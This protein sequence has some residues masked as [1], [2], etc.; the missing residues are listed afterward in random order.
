MLPSRLTT[1]ALL[2]LACRSLATQC[3]IT[4]VMYNPPA[5]KPEYIEVTNLTSNRI[6][7]AKW[8]LT[9][10]VEFTFPDFNA[11]ASS[12]HF[13]KE[14]ERIVLSSA[15]EATT[16]AAYPGIP[17]NVR[18]FGP[19]TGL[20]DNNGE[21][22]TLVDF[23]N[24]LQASMSYGDSGQWPRAADG[25]GHS[26]QIINQNRKVD[27]WRN[28]RAS[29]GR[30]GSPG[31]VEAAQ[32]EE[33]VGNPEQDVRPTVT[34]KN[35]ADT[36]KY[37]RDLADPD[38]AN[39]EGT[40]MGTAFN[41][42]AW[43]SGPGLFARETA[44][45]AV[46]LI[47]TDFIT[48]Y[49]SSLLS[50]Y[51]RT[52]F[53]WT[54]AL[55][56]TS[57]TLDQYLDD[58]VIYYLNGVE[59]KGA[60]QGRVRMPAGTVTHSTQ[61]NA[62]VTDA[63]EE[64][65]A[66]SGTLDGQLVS[67]TN[68]LCAE[69]H[70]SGTSSS[71]I[72]FGARLKLI[73][74]APVGVVLNEVKPGTAGSGFVEFYNPT[75]A[76]IDLQNYYLS[77]T[78][79]NLT[80]YQIAT[81]LVVPSLG[82]ATVGFAE[83]NLAIASPVVVILTQPD[84]TTRQA[85]ISASMAADGRSL[86]RKPAGSASWF[87]FSSP[88]P[89]AP[90]FS[91]GGTGGGA[92]LFL[93]EVHFA[94]T[95]RVD[96]VEFY[97]PATSALS[98]TGF[99]VA[100]RADLTD[101]VAL[102]GSIPA[103]G[104]ASMALDFPTDGNGDITLYLTDAGD[105]VL[106]TAAVERRTGLPSVQS[107]PARSSEWY[108]STTDTRDAA[109]NPA[110]STDIVINEI[111]YDPPSD[112]TNGEYI[113]ITNRGAAPVNLGLWRFNRGVD[114]DF[115]ANTM[116]APGEFIVVA[117]DPGYV[118]AT[119]GG[120]VRVFG[121][122]QGRLSNGGDYVRLED[123][124]QN[125]ADVV[126]YKDGGN[127]PLLAGGQGSSMEL[128]H[129]GMDNS[130]P[131]SWRASN[132]ANKAPFQ[133]YTH[134]G[135]Y[136]E[137]RTG[138]HLSQANGRALTETREL[139]LHHV[140]DGHMVLKN[141]R[142]AAAATPGTNIITTGDA[143][144]HTGNGANGF[145]CMGTHRQ[146]D[147]LADGFHLISAGGGDV[148]AN[149]AEVDI[150]GITGSVAAPGTY[151]LS[152]DARWVSGM[153][154]LVAQTW[155]RSFG[156]VFRLP[157][158]NNLGTPGAA[159][160][161]AAPSAPP[162]VD[163]ISHSPAVPTSTQAVIVTARVTSAEPLVSVS[164]RER[165]DSGATSTGPYSTVA[166]N[167][168]GTGADTTAG[169]GIWSA[170]VPA[171]AVN[172]IT[173]FFVRAT[174][175]GGQ[176]NQCPR[177]AESVAAV[178]GTSLSVYGRP[179]MWIVSNTP[180]SSQPGILTER[181]IFSQYDRNAMNS[182]TG[183]SATYDWDFPRMSN[184]GLNSTMIFNESEVIYNCELR[185]GGSP[186]TRNGGNTM[187]RARWRSPS[188]NL[189]RDRTKNAIDS[190]GNGGGT[191]TNAVARFHNRISRY[192]M[193]LFGY[194]I[195]DAE[196]VQYIVNGDDPT[197]RDEMEMTDTDFFDRAYGEGGEL[198]E[199]DDAWYMYDTSNHDERIDA[200]Q[201]TGR[202]SLTDW[203]N[204][205]IGAN[206]SD[207]SPIFFHGNWP[208]RFPESTYDYASLSSF[209]KLTVN[210]GQPVPVTGTASD[211]VLTSPGHGLATA[212][213]VIAQVVG[214]GGIINGATYY[215]IRL[216]ADTFKLATT[217][218]NANNGIAVNFNTDIT[219]GYVQPPFTDTNASGIA[220]REQIER[221]ID[222]DRAGIY[223]AVRGYIGDWDNFT[224]N[225]GK[226][227]YFYRRATDGKFEFH[228]WDSDLAFQGTGELFIG[229]TGGTGWTN[230]SNRPW[231][232]Q[233]MYYYLTQLVTRFT[234]GSPRMN[235]WLDAMNYQSAN[236]HA[237][238]PFKT[239]GYNYP[240][241][242]F[243]TR[244]TNAL[245]FVGA[246]NHNR[247]FSVTTANNQTVATPVFNLAGAASTRTAYV[248]VAGHPEALF[249]W[250]P[251]SATDVGG[252]TI[253]GL[254]LANGLNALS[255]RAIG[256]D[257][258]LISSIA[259][260]VTLSVN[261]PP[262]AVVTA[263]PA[264][265]RVAANEEVVLDAT[266]SYDPEA[267]PLAYTWSVNPSTGATI[268]HS[269]PGKTEARFTI[270]GIYT[271]T[272]TV[273]DGAALQTALATEIT[274]FNAQDFQPFPGGAPLGPDWTVQ[275]VELRDNFSPS[276]WYSVEDTTGRLMIHV[277]DDSA[278]PLASPAFTHP[279]VTRDLPDTSDFVL[280]TDLEPDTRELGNWQSG[281]WLE[282]IEGGSA[283]RY[284]FSLDGGLNAVVRRAVQPGA[285]ATSASQSVTGSGATLRIRR[286][287]DSLVFQRLNGGA[288]ATVHTQAINNP[289]VA[290][291]GGVFVSTSQPTTVRVSFDYILVSDP[292]ASDSVL[293]NLRVTEIMYNPDGPGG[294]EFIELTNTGSQPIELAGCY[295]EEGRP[296]AQ[297]TFPSYVLAPGAFVI[298]T[299]VT[300]AVF[301]STY[302][303]TP[304]GSIF[305]WTAGALSNGG[306]AITLRD[307]F[308][309][310]IQDFNYDDDPLANWPQPPDGG[311]F[312]LEVVSTTGDYNSAANW[313]S[314][315]ETGGSPGWVGAGPDTDNDGYSDRLEQLAG[316]NAGDGGN[317][318]NA[319]SQML[320]G[321]QKITW[322]SVPGRTYRIETSHDLA[323]GSWT[324]RGTVVHPTGDPAGIGE[325]TVADP[326]PANNVRTYYRVTVALTP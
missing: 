83:S 263:D 171:R 238:A 84:G 71:D 47:G 303:Q 243:T 255:V 282:M 112:H 286:L 184:F 63:A 278:K 297:F 310:I 194:P 70:Q 308:G 284:A 244:D 56:G 40:W 122:W 123:S 55:T 114:Y 144:S 1:A 168:S 172:T 24:T 181:H 138:T 230:F 136:K 227:G 125:L 173:Q 66:L 121:P 170:S 291:S 228:H 54:G 4:E 151:I 113:E 191:G 48:G 309:N 208:L 288:W 257:G 259:F 60:D 324:L 177:D 301:S 142:L 13:L 248:E 262:V 86:G 221:A 320:P 102:G 69:V 7:A 210:L 212:N 14:Y 103:G 159:N 98:G 205:S 147:T 43:L 294:I 217:I 143:T 74:S 52:T 58:G 107:W 120:S 41:D 23:S 219:G 61:A 150:T 231:F 322:P 145:L 313:T 109:N 216:T 29:G 30:L 110:R 92:P 196:F 202:W 226:N 268:G 157:I 81:S 235:A 179:A 321:G 87:L 273:T 73:G 290:G 88:T 325:F 234:G 53:E 156:K 253:T 200:A 225:R 265:R 149:K 162:T 126:D 119:Y 134:T 62:V 239:S 35:Y 307:S 193:Y 78:A 189:F 188:D 175:T 33:P 209:I 203:A 249:T 182:G 186:W 96:W 185:K 237:N 79:G 280:Q 260:N 6:D 26:L 91:S 296:F 214:G 215:V 275:N 287:G 315:V 82:Y 211:D 36:W 276:S 10:G 90:N 178:N 80:K 130:Q 250:T 128:L 261:A 242:W 302:P 42:T 204:A 165:I 12:A 49:N 198:F 316:T 152:F 85:H 271:V 245:N 223:A 222:V 100:S 116:I 111:M 18:V 105:N 318:F 207:E 129:P 132:E 197:W 269:V 118:T 59:L 169:D 101:K 224:L 93:S 163:S 281:L 266:A 20:L 21:S 108:A 76:A 148:K 236:P 104:Y 252:W 38:G 34:L 258:A 317:F 39:P 190:D 277:L 206:P 45:A 272:A 240:G 67:G 28:W 174:T 77:D 192:M 229:T 167:D 264:S 306:E 95:G 319:A 241:T 115:P 3:A 15:N 5:G 25:A 153:P 97:N 51:F 298:V 289:S 131:S 251:A 46:P 133:S 11:G 50:Y 146:S 305:Q 27:D 57:F 137:L 89:G 75:G 270:P 65:A 304:P 117:S 64:L 293:A 247:T 201:V 246:A 285:W 139:L 326:S 31:Y 164:L 68:V 166:M 323:A 254:R 279:V 140:S 124:N 155:D 292:A 154:L 299:N 160:S 17:P 274:V 283:V 72:V 256:G 180:P 158:P 312:S 106:G 22:I 300:P 311:G 161:V 127:W 44:G 176:S 199:I 8:R 195:P 135:T 267:T 183:F 141:I 213:N 187:E 2:C 314:G 232:R 218:N 99:F 19:W 16:R 32:A 37:W 94:G 9:G 295:F 220:W 233:R